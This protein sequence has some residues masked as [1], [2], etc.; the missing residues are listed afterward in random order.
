M[1]SQQELTL[2]VLYLVESIRKR[3]KMLRVS[4]NGKLLALILSSVIIIFSLDLR[5]ISEWIPNQRLFRTTAIH[6]FSF[7][8]LQH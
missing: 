1:C 3:R 8:C 4:S 7:D 5:I 6:D 2:L